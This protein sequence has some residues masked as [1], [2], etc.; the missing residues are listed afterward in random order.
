YTVEK[1]T[2][3]LLS[4]SKDSPKFFVI[5]DEIERAR[6]IT[7]E[8]IDLVF[9]QRRESFNLRPRILFVF[10]EAQEFLPADDSRK[11]GEGVAESSKSVERL[12]RHGRKY[13]LHGWIS[14]Q[15]LAHLNTNA[16]HQIHS[17]FVGTLPRPY[18]RQLV[19]DTFAIDDTLLERSLNFAPGDWMLAS[20]RAT[21][22]QNVPVFF[23]AINNEDYILPKE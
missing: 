9:K 21:K 18:D 15:R 5:N 4:N 14:T 7:A 16:L 22:T 19:G 23:H 6:E 11:A 13:H 2:A 10:D 1:L 3:E 12:L 8:I 20:F 17:Y